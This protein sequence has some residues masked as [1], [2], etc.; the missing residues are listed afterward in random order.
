[1]SSKTVKGTASEAVSETDNV[2]ASQALQTTGDGDISG[3]LTLALSQTARDDAMRQFME[4]LH[5]VQEGFGDLTKPGDIYKMDRAFDVIDA[6]TITDYVDQK[7]GEVKTKH[8]FKLQFA[9]GDVRMVMQSTAGPRAALASL[10]ASARLLGERI[11]VG[12]YKFTEKAIPHQI[13]AAI[14]F[15]QQPG[16]AVRPRRAAATA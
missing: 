14:I 1:M 10:F 16:F 8:V 7:T 4:E 9:E 2:N 15:V 3:P 12:P 11:A 6:T 5:R 13:Q